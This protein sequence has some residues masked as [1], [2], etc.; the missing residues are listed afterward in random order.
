LVKL[1]NGNQVERERRA[2]TKTEAERRLKEAIAKE[3]ANSGS[4]GLPYAEQIR[5]GGRKSGR[6]PTGTNHRVARRPSL[7]MA[8]KEHHSGRHKATARTNVTL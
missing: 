3:I 1:M 4:S 7:H 6:Y 8:T 2:R 5:A